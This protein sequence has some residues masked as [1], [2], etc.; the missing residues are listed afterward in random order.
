MV[1]HL[2]VWESKSSPGLISGVFLFLM[3]PA[4]RLLLGRWRAASRALG[5]RERTV[6]A[7]Y[8]ILRRCED[9][10]DEAIQKSLSLT[11]SFPRKRESSNVA[12]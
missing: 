6:R 4:P 7:S 5:R 12:A 3:C 8:P 1:L 10:G 11:L 9:H 2:K